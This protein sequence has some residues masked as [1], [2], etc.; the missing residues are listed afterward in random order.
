MVILRSL[1]L[2]LLLITNA[3]SGNRISGDVDIN[4]S[5]N[6]SMVSENGRT[7]IGSVS[8]SDVAGS[9]SITAVVDS[10]VV[11]KNGETRIAC[12]DGWSGGGVSIQV[13]VGSVV[14]D[15]AGAINIGCKK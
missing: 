2:S 3:T 11:T 9:V 6:G 7:L 14:N 12:V 10:S 5:V 4:V 8:N 13:F 15:G 1:F